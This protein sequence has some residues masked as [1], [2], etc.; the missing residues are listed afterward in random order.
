MAWVKWMRRGLAFISCTW[1]KTRTFGVPFARS[2]VALVYIVFEIVVRVPVSTYGRDCS[3]D[4]VQVSYGLSDVFFQVH[5]RVFFLG[6]PDILFSCTC[7]RAWGIGIHGG[8][9]EAFSGMLGICRLAFCL[10]CLSKK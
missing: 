9:I 3:C 5:L 2:M 7:S 4:L 8:K 1:R 6:K 10:H